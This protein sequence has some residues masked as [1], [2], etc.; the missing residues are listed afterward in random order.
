MDRIFVVLATVAISAGCFG[1]S[2]GGTTLTDLS[3]VP[4]V[5]PPVEAEV[6]QLSGHIVS[7]AIDGPSHS[8]PTEDALWP[9]QQQGHLVNVA[10]GV[11]E[12][13]VALAWRG[14]G[15]LM[16]MLHSHKAHGTNVYVE[17]VSAM[18]EANPKCIRVPLEDVLPGDWQVMVHSS[19]AESTD[20]EILVL[21]V[22]PR[23]TLINDRHG[24]WPQDGAFE[25]DEH[26]VEACN[27]YALPE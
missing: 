22:G 20:W 13:E 18:D 1:N 5:E 17:H 14:P 21:T 16:I 26:E 12:L 15:D 23:A 3:E 7:S 25:V 2:G 4:G 6:L 11:T 27:L 10:E 8:R 9:V 24:H 19:G